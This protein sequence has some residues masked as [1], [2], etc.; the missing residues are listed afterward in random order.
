MNVSV[1]LLTQLTSG[2]EVRIGRTLTQ[3][4]TWDNHVY[5]VRCYSGFTVSELLFY[6]IQ[7]LKLSGSADC[8]SIQR[9]D[10]TEL[11]SLTPIPF[12]GFQEEIRLVNR[13][14]LKKPP[15]YV[16][17]PANPVSGTAGCPPVFTIKIG[18]NGVYNSVIVKKDDFVETVLRFYLQNTLKDKYSEDLVKHAILQC[19]N[20][21]LN[22][23]LKM[24]QCGIVRKQLD[25]PSY[26]YH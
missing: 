7:S 20:R 13:N 21:V 1:P 8:Y 10:G 9:K 23:G 16:P 3:S 12:N 19:N 4:V 15:P 5:D 2:S 11:P 14:T 26:R 17:K 24:Y 18:I 6:C 22:K 25:C